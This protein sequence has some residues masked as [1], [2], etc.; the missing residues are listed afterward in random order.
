MKQKLKLGTET[1]SFQNWLMGNNNTLPEVGK[2]ATVLSWTDR[3]AYEVISVSDDKKR[4]TIKQYIS[5]RTGGN[6]MSE[7]QTYKYEKLNPIAEIIVWKWGAWR[8]E[9]ERLE[10]LD[11]NKFEQI[12]SSSDKR[13]RALTKMKEIDGVTKRKKEY[14]KINIIFGVKDEH[15]DYSF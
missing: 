6:G 8:E 13:D 1:G 12:Y 4:V 9:L 15:Y 10:V 3:H 7:C 2:G 14:R 11:W 5:E